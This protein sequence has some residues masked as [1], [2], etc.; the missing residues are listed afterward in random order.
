MPEPLTL[1]FYTWFMDEDHHRHLRMTPTQYTEI[2][3]PLM[4]KGAYK[5]PISLL[6]FHQA[7]RNRL[8]CSFKI[9]KKIKKVDI[10]RRG[11]TVRHN[12]KHLTR[13]DFYLKS[14]TTK[15]NSVVAHCK[16][17][18]YYPPDQKWFPMNVFKRVLIKFKK[19]EIKM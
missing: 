12:S 6:I 19:C 17:L 14:N 13:V 15:V 7:P 16:S 9:N 1:D 18:Y 11:R 10:G 8:R 5:L 3:V 4:Q 2:T